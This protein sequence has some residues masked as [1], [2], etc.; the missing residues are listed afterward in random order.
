[1][2]NRRSTALGYLAT[3][4]LAG[5]FPTRQVKLIFIPGG[6][7]KAHEVSSLLAMQRCFGP[8]QPKHLTCGARWVEYVAHTLQSPRSFGGV[9]WVG[10]SVIL[11]RCL[12]Y[13]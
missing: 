9:Q 1:M 2:P 13:F 7:P 12:R 10:P 5:T 11:L 8:C 4:A 6:A 3:A